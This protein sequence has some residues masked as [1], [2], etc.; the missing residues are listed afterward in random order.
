MKLV[1]IGKIRTSFRSKK[2]TPIQTTQ[3]R[4]TGRAEVFKKYQKGL[5]D[6]DGF[7][8]IILIYWF[9]RSKGYSLKVTPFLDTVRRGLFSTRYPGRPN[10]IGISIV[11]L[12]KRK[13]N[14]LYVRGIDVLD[15][16]PLLD[17]KPYLPQLNPQGKIKVGWLTGKIQ[18]MKSKKGRKAS[19]QSS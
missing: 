17:I 16:T 15:N 1:P 12:L 19:H 6:L 3:S 2:V 10:Q 18:K 9:H 8:H 13:G 14:I 4:E 11:E 5:D 7:S